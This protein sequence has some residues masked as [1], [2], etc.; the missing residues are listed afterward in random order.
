MAIHKSLDSLPS[1]VD[2]FISPKDVRAITSLGWNTILR[3]IENGE[4]PAPYQISRQR[5]GFRLSEVTEW[6][7]GRA[8][9]PAAPVKG[10]RLSEAVANAE[11]DGA[12]TGKVSNQ[13]VAAT[14]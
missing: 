11:Q 12:R 4:F 10:D 2:R 5:I 3:K 7:N 1:G 13:R 6:M 8:R 14:R 9:V